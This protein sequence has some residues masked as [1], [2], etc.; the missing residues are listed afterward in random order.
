M[1]NYCLLR[2]G[3]GGRDIGPLMA[4]GVSVYACFR[5]CCATV[6]T[7]VLSVGFGYT[8]GEVKLAFFEHLRVCLLV[9]RVRVLFLVGSDFG[10]FLLFL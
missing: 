3:G 9:E 5:F 10:G 2:Y 4:F 6:T 7:V 1:K 8:N